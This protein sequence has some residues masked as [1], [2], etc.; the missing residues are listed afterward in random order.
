[1]SRSCQSATF[2]KPTSALAR[3]TRARPQIR[4][5][6]TGFRLCGI[7][8]EPFCPR[9]NGSCTSATS[10][11]AR[12]RISS[13]KL[14]SEE[15]TTASVVSS[16]AWRSRWRIWVELGAGSTIAAGSLY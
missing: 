2:S 9:P 3:T 7:D 10:V 5:A 1:M 4:S 11:R 13:A 6:T 15:A 8:D 16:S 12:C 14:S